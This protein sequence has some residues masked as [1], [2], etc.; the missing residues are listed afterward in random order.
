MKDLA[1]GRPPLTGGAVRQR[2]LHRLGELPPGCR[3]GIGRH[4]GHVGGKILAHVL[5]IREQLCAVAKYRVVAHI[6][7]LDCRQHLR[8]HLGVEALVRLNLVRLDADQLTKPSHGCSPVWWV[9]AAP[10]PATSVRSGRYRLRSSPASWYYCNRER[11]SAAS[12][13]A[14]RLPDRRSDR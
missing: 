4:P 6:A 5:E 14:V 3:R 13:R 7:C 1:Y 10:R 12:S 11:Y 2:L 8:P 9:Q